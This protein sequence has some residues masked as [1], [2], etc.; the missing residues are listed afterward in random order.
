MRPGC[1]TPKQKADME[2]CIREETA[3]S[4]LVLKNDSGT[5]VLTAP[6]G[7]GTD[8]DCSQENVLKALR[9][10][11]GKLHDPNTPSVWSEPAVYQTPAARARAEADRIERESAEI[12]WIKCVV[13]SCPK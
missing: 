1:Y 3:H 7:M 13:A 11:T 8:C 6:K 2:G 5:I 10:A 4:S 9:L 12:Q